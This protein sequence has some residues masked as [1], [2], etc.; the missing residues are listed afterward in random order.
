[1]VIL[2]GEDEFGISRFVAERE[3]SLEGASHSLLDITRLDA[4]SLRLE[5]L[6]NVVQTLPFLSAQ[7]LIVLHHAVQRFSAPSQRKDFLALLSNIPA[8]TELILVEPQ[9]LSEDHWLIAWASKAGPEVEV[10]AFPLLKEAAMSRWIQ[11]HARESGGEFTPAA[12]ARLASFVGSDT[13]QADQEIQKLLAYVNRN[14]SVQ[15]DDVSLLSAFSGHVDVFPMV[16]A[17][18]ERN[19][20]KALRMLNRLLVDQEAIMVFGMIIRQFRLLIQGREVLDSGGSVA[21]LRQIGIHPM[22]ADKIISQARNFSMEQLEAWYHRLL[23]VDEEIKTG[24]VDPD[25]ALELLIVE[26]TSRT[27]EVYR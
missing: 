14:R 13:R 25:I 27:G 4:R 7:R 3:A 9:K 24:V 1:M 19:G 26:F 12:A 22:V 8:S 16:D 2:Y 11:A 23:E 10:K 15:P 18:G 17:L 6:I 21:S 20:Q 5:E